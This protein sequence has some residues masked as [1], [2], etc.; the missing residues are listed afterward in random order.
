M[1]KSDALTALPMA[2]VTEIRPEPV[3]PGTVVE[4]DVE[5]AV[6]TIA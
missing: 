5:V 6:L 4:R 1:K 3:P 2:V